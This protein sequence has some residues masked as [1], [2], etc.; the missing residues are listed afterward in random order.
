MACQHR[1][2]WSQEE[3][4]QK[5]ALSITWTLAQIRCSGTVTLQWWHQHQETPTWQSATHLHLIWQHLRL[6]THGWGLQHSLIWTF[7]QWR[8]QWVWHHKKGKSSCFT[9]CF[10]VVKMA[11]AGTVRSARD[12]L[13]PRAASG[14]MPASTQGKGPTS[15]STA[16][17]HSV[18]PPPSV[19]T[20]DCTQERSHTSVRSV[21]E[22]SLSQLGSDL[23]ARHIATT[24]RG[25][26]TTRNWTTIHRNYHLK[27][28]P[29]HHHTAEFSLN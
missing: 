19:H 1:T 15:A 10:L 22:R 28:G 24:P 26:R 4:R 14:H 6:Q 13:A 7:P 18:K 20:R 11:A 21:A 23:I 9:D 5:I 3:P 29:T 27:T 8:I 2:R 12:C 25:S 16:W 17:G